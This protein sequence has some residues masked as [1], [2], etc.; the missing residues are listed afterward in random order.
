[1][2]FISSLAIAADGTPATEE[3]IVEADRSKIN[4]KL[5]VDQAE[6]EFYAI[7]NEL[8]DDEEFKI[9]CRTQRVIGSLIHKRICQTKYM[10]DELTNS[11]QLYQVGVNYLADEVLKKKNRELRQKTIELLETNPKLLRAARKL[12]G[13]VEEYQ[14]EYGIE[15]DRE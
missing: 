9:E 14:D 2:Y 3:I 11:A 5:Q 12:S 4:L 7:L 15:V 13:R 8:I 6:N 1:M 10:K